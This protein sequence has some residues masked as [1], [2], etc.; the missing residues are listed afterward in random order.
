MWYKKYVFYTDLKNVHLTFIKS[1]PK[2]SFAHK[3]Y[4]E[5]KI[6]HL[7]EGTINTF[8]ELKGQKCK[9]HAQYFEKRF[10]FIHMS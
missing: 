5:K 7:L 2:T 4:L 1:E 9:K 3:K 6:F 10:F 8:W